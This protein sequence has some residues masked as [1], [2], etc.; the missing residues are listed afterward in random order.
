MDKKGV[1]RM[2]ASILESLVLP[3]PMPF[4]LV[5]EG[6]EKGDLAVVVVVKACT[7][8]AAPRL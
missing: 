2:R 5:F 8:T 4:S 7:A 1:S 6:E 3:C